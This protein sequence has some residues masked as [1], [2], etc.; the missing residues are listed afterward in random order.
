MISRP[1]SYQ[2]QEISGFLYKIVSSYI[3]N[4]NI[5]IVVPPPFQMRLSQ[6][7]WEPDLIFLRA[8][9]QS[10]LKETY[11]DGP[12]NIVVEITSPESFAQ[13]RGE[14]FCAYEEAG[15]QEYWL[16]DPLRQQTEWYRLSDQHRYLPAKLDASGV[17]H[18]QV[19][20]G[21]WLNPHW[22]WR[23]PMPATEW[24]TLQIGGSARAREMLE[25]LRDIVGRDGLWQLM[26]E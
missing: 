9:Q 22:L 16:I 5:G 4:Q 19:L 17:Y 21:F 8:E 14:R 24:V 1:T 15:V 26:Q 13:D 18:S 3:E 11:L 10:R 6:G 2:H 20:A 7:T 23:S 12:A 25:A